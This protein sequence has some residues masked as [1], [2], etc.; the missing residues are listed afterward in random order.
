MIRVLSKPLGGVDNPSVEAFVVANQQ[1]Q[2]MDKSTTSCVPQRMSSEASSIVSGTSVFSSNDD[3]DDYSID[4]GRSSLSTSFTSYYSSKYYKGGKDT[5]LAEDI[6][7]EVE[8]YLRDRGLLGDNESY[9]EELETFWKQQTNR[10]SS[11]TSTIFR[12]G[13][14]EEEA[15]E[16]SDQDEDS[17][18]TPSDLLQVVSSTLRGRPIHHHHGIPTTSGESPTAAGYACD[19]LSRMGSF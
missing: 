1:Q 3:D 13:D 5:F 18:S 11:T 14:D 9:L 12:D 2:Q 16:L 8:D 7:D 6:L 17:V 19:A 15:S 4:T 10:F